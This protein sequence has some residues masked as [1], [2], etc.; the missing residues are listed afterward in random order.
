MWQELRKKSC[1]KKRGA[2]TSPQYLNIK[3]LLRARALRALPHGCGESVDHATVIFL[4]CSRQDL[5]L[6]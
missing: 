5:L 1:L 2:L 6:A 3:T 4:A